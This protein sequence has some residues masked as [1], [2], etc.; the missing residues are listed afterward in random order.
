MSSYRVDNIYLDQVHTT[1]WRVYSV[2]ENDESLERP[3][4][5]LLMSDGYCMFGAGLVEENSEEP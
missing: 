1:L 3:K 5:E 4:E 2:I